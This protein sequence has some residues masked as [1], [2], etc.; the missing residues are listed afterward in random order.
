MNTQLRT[1][2]AMIIDDV[3][4][5][6]TQLRIKLA[7]LFPEIKIVAECADGK[8]G[9]H[10]IELHQPDLVFLD[11][12]MPV[13]TGIEMLEQIQNP[14]FEVIFISVS[15]KFAIQAMR[16]SALDY[17]VKP[18]N[19]DELKSAIARF[20]AKKNHDTPERLKNLLHNVHTNDEEHKLALHSTDGIR[21]IPIKEIMYCKAQGSYTQIY[22]SNNK[23]ETASK[24]LHDFEEMLA[25]KQFIRIHKSN[26]VNK[27]FV[28]GISYKGF[29]ILKGNKPVEISKRRFTEVKKE[30]A[31]IKVY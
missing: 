28:D 19:V 15:D 7:K 18:F 30:L 16:L 21:F 24:P 9:M 13:M 2:K 1:Y 20:K 10:A 25:E 8:E 29:V 27:K 6:R 5:N 11:V 12:M 23:M 17:L 22:L 14:V 26:M 3:S 4:F 31:G